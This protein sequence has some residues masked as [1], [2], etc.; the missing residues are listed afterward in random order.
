M[1][2]QP[3]RINKRAREQSQMKNFSTYILNNEKTYYYRI[4]TILNIGPY[5][6]S[7]KESD[8]SNERLTTIEKSLSKY[9]LITME[10]VK[11]TILQRNPLDFTN[12]E[13]KEVYILDVE[14]GL[15]VS[16]TE[17]CDRLTVALNAPLGFIIVCGEHDPVEMQNQMI[18][19]VGEIEQEAAD[20]G[21]EP[22]SALSDPTNS[23]NYDPSENDKPE[24][25]QYGD[26]YNARLLT[27][28]NKLRDAKAEGDDFNADI[29]DAPS[30][31][32]TETPGEDTETIYVRRTFRDASGK[33]HT[34]SKKL[35]RF[36]PVEQY[37]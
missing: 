19:K 17:M 9:D 30:A 18:Y 28:F 31:H 14:L 27:Y 4:K 15:P 16:T 2:G 37:V 32:P 35:D 26:K 22:A 12:V 8:E 3:P 33:L 5:G 11:K 25:I 6:A 36:G 24:D 1:L 21:W 10:R 20:K 29:E 34:I 23:E 13:N 7:K